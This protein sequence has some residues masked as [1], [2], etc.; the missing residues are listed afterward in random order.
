MVHSKNMCVDTRQNRCKNR[1]SVQDAPQAR[2]RG[3][4]QFLQL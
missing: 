1:E 2:R 3:R 4:E